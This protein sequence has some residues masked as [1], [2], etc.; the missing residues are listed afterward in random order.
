LQSWLELI[1]EYFPLKYGNYEPLRADLD[2]NNLESALEL[3]AWP[4]LLKRNRPKMEGGVWMGGGARPT[5]GWIH[6]AFDFNPTFQR[7]LV[8]FLQEVSVKF[9]ADFAFLHL[10]TDREVNPDDGT[11]TISILNKNHANLSVTTHDLVKYIPDVYWG[12]VFGRPY[13]DFFGGEKLLFSPVQIAKR[14]SPDAIYL[15]LSDNLLD[16]ET[17][18]ETLSDIRS[19]VKT[20]LNNNAFFNEN[21]GESHTYN[22]PQFHF[23]TDTLI[24]DKNKG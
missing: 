13:M 16:L 23:L 15:Q 20:H 24:R 17:N 7:G 5:H 21:L 3:W 11:G 8:N 2:H 9:S 19:S 1:P 14:L 22:A 4:F 12:M 18:F 10:L 6:I